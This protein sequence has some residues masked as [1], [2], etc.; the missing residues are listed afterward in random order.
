MIIDLLFVRL[1]QTHDEIFLAL[2]LLYSSAD[3]T[4]LVQ[5]SGRN[6]KCF[7]VALEYIVHSCT[8]TI[9]ARVMD[10]YI[11]NVSVG[12]AQVLPK[13]TQSHYE[14]NDMQSLVWGEPEFTHV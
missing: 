3:S 12:L 5:M 14:N 11:A 6:L 8:M 7:H 1:F 9:P 2:A 13:Y 10:I 4:K